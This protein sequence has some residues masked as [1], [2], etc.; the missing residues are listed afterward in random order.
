V[1]L[2]DPYANDVGAALAASNANI[3]QVRSAR[4]LAGYVVALQAGGVS[5]KWA[6]VNLVNTKS[7]PRCRIVWARPRCC[8]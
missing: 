8:F 6:Q 4:D 1:G 5:E 2:S 7:L 3:D